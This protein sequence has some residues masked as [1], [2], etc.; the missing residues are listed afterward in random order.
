MT[1]CHEL[2]VKF[3]ICWDLA[4][5]DRTTITDL[6]VS[7]EKFLS[8]L[9]PAEFSGPKKYSFVCCTSILSQS[10]AVAPVAGVDRVRPSRR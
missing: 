10:P 2:E 5:S 7:K 9:N 8:T 1:R 3:A 4:F 6:P